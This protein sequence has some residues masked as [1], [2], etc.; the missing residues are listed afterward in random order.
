[1]TIS[2]EEDAPA[3]LA[4]K[5]V[6][7]AG[8]VHAKDNALGQI[9]KKLR[10]MQGVSDHEPG[11]FVIIIPQVSAPVIIGSKGAQIKS[12]MEQSGAEINVGREVIIGMNDMPI[13]INGTHDQ[14]GSAVSKLNGVLQDMV[15]RGKLNESDFVYRNPDEP[16][17][18]YGAP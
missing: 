13:S 16:S 8:L 9:V 4:D 5:I 1:M 6:S 3:T 10:Q 14:V 11:V 18:S 17:N 15:D 7:I 2:K 12:I